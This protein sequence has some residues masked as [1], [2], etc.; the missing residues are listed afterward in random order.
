MT[1]DWDFKQ[2][3]FFASCYCYDPSWE[4]DYKKEE[5]TLYR[6]NRHRTTQFFHVFSN[7]SNWSSYLCGAYIKQTTEHDY[8][9]CDQ[10][11]PNI[12]ICHLPVTLHDSSVSTADPSVVTTTSTTSPTRLCL[13]LSQ[14]TFT[15]LGSITSQHNGEPTYSS[16]PS[17]SYTH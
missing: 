2:K 4:W 3:R 10:W 16:R 12:N 7:S 1:D 5:S 14:L 9:V 13:T 15:H 8:E 6:V 17:L 11:K